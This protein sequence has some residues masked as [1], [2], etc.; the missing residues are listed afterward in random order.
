VYG[1]GTETVA[2]PQ[3]K[4]DKGGII[5]KRSR[6]Y[7]ILI[8]ITATFMFLGITILVVPKA[9]TAAN[10]ETKE[11][12]QFNVGTTMAFN[13]ASLKGKLITVTLSS[14]QTLT[15][16]VSDAKDN[17]LHLTKITQREFYDALI[18][19]NHISAIEMKVR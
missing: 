13:L 18:A 7:A 10:T 6:V 9:V 12:I 14:G 2:R 17:L 8:I 3:E 1:Y 4:L 19:I 11:A 5:M 15:G 16:V